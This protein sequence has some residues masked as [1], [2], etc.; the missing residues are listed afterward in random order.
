MEK[1]E[2][3]IQCE[4]R[5]FEAYGFRSAVNGAVVPLSPIDKI[6]YVVMRDRYNF[7]VNKQKGKY[8]ESQ[9]TTA[10]RAGTFRRKVN[11]TVKMFMEHGI[12]KGRKE[13]MGE[14]IHWVYEEIHPLVLCK[15]EGDLFLRDKLKTREKPPTK[16]AIYSSMNNY[17]IEDEDDLPW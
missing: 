11:E 2:E 7:F 15:K 13:K 4:K 16:E 8:H 12:I 14:H 5:L 17:S 3:F 10:E 6:I 1:R 9:E